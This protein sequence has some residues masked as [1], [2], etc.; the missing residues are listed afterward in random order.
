MKVVHLIVNKICSY[1]SMIQHLAY[2]ARHADKGHVTL[3]LLMPKLSF[4]IYISMLSLVVLAFQWITPAKILFITGVVY[5]CCIFFRF[6][7][8]SEIKSD[9]FQCKK[10]PLY[11]IPIL[12]ETVILKMCLLKFNDNLASAN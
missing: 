12:K 11:S 5:Y 10:C 1:F 8:L 4:Q 2:L 7:I 6:S 9:V 3:S